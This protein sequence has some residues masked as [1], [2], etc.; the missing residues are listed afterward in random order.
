MHL[1]L[2]RYRVLAATWMPRLTLFVIVKIEAHRRYQA[3]LG[4]TMRSIPPRKRCTYLVLMSIALTT[5][6]GAARAE[7]LPS[8]MAPIGG[9]TTSDAAATARKDVLAL[10]TVMFQL[11][12]TSGAIFRRNLMADHPRVVLRRWRT[13]HLVPPWQGGARSPARADHLS[14]HEIGGTQH[15]GPFRS[16]DALSRKSRRQVVARFAA[17]LS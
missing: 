13:F 2:H 11:Y 15:H 14:A 3:S 9:H 12:D 10:N 4:E 7:D 6:A 1:I 8:Y 17:G 5:T 16:A